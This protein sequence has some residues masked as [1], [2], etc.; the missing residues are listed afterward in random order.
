MT[1]PRWEPLSVEGEPPGVRP[2]YG[3]MAAAGASPT[4]QRRSCLES[5]RSRGGALLLLLLTSG[6]LLAATLSGLREV[7]RRRAAPRACADTSFLE[8]RPLTDDPQVGARAGR[9]GQMLANRYSPQLV[10][11]LYLRMLPF[12]N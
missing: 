9:I 11:M 5:A 8:D 3:L 7:A 6:L 10:R 4:T 2:G 12:G 1:L